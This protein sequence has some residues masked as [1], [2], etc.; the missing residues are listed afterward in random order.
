M[1]FKFGHFVFIADGAGADIVAET[2]TTNDNSSPTTSYLWIVAS[3]SE[4]NQ[5]S[6]RIDHSASNPVSFR[7][8]DL[9]W[10]DG[11]DMVWGFVK[12][13]DSKR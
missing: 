11:L 10:V 8:Q 2:M 3:A 9:K 7:G 1:S 12:E 6:S 5:V 4:T 13:L